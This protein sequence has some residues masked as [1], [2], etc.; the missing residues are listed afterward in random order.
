M[1][2]DLKKKKSKKKIISWKNPLKLNIKTLEKEKK[3]KERK[4]KI[5]PPAVE[6]AQEKKKGRLPIHILHLG[7][8]YFSSN[9]YHL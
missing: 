9:P 8:D 1:K 5:K 6:P 7:R 3:P 2:S 4:S